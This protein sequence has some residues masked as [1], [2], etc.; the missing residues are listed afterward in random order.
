MIRGVGPEFAG[1][2]VDKFGMHTLEILD[3]DPD[4]I[5]EVPVSD[6]AGPVPSRR[7]G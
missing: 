2:I 5:G 3:A 1:R 4:R 6:P 7:P